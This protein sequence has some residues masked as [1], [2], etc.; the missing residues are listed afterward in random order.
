LIFAMLTQTEAQIYLASL[1]GH[2]QTENFRSLR[3]LNF[4][5]YFAEGREPFGNLL[6]FNDETLLAE[7]GHELKVNEACQVI[8]LPLVGAIEIK[9]GENEGQFVNSGEALI[10]NPRPNGSYMITNPYPDEA[11]N[12]LQIRLGNA[13]SFQKNEVTLT[14]FHFSYNNT[15]QSVWNAEDGRRNVFVGQYKGREE[16][17]F[18]TSRENSSVFIFIIQGAFEVQNRL[19]E[20]RD[21]LSI[22]GVQEI[23]FEALSN[24]AVILVFELG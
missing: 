16:G 19:L 10:L 13:G 14:R 2:F 17:V 11:I 20:A 5:D 7:C 24:D 23:E 3:T 22:R 15:L 9:S 6:V 1:R 8:L 21:A 18:L 12:Y 4:E